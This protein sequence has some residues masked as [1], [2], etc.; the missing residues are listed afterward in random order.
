MAIPSFHPTAE[1]DQRP[2]MGRRS[3]RRRIAGW[4]GPAIALLLL[5]A[6]LRGTDWVAL[7]HI[8]AG[9]H[10]GYLLLALLTVLATIAAKAAR[11]RTL[12]LEQSVPWSRFFA[13]I[14]VG[15]MANALL[16]GRAGDVLRWAMLGREAPLG[17]GL[18]LGSVAAEKALDGIMLAALMMGIL[19][20]TPPLVVLDTGQALW[21]VGATSAALLAA[22]GILRVAK[23]RE[24]LVRLIAGVVG[25]R[26]AGATAHLDESLGRIALALPARIRPWMESLAIWML[27]GLTNWCLLR[28]FAQHLPWTAV[29]LLLVALHFGRFVTVAPGQVGIFH[30]IALLVLGLYGVGH[31]T[32][33]AVGLVLHLFVILPP[34]LLGIFYLRGEGL[35]LGEDARALAGRLLRGGEVEGTPACDGEK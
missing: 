21:A 8:L 15:Q 5:A 30:Y 1:K 20:L 3:G 33:L 19:P 25:R 28:A 13:G 27:A 18:T 35:R 22:L 32:A 2:S 31:D 29:P 14:N 17:Y 12:C 26:H 6:S 24:G 23:V 16:P 11:W 7:G 4:I 9:A 10:L 34:I